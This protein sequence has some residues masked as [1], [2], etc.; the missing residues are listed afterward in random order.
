M[1]AL[2]LADKKILLFQKIIAIEN[3]NILQQ[4][5]ILIDKIT[6]SQI[7]NFDFDEIE[8][9]IENLT[10]DEWLNKYM[11]TKDLNQNIEEYDMT[12]F[13]YRKKIYDSEKSKSFPIN[14]FLNKLEQYA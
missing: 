4:L 7:S 10:F 14:L 3:E 1:I 5:N 9:D 12:L 13:E 11:I 8:E 2:N 6:S